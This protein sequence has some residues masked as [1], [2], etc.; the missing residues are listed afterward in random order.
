MQGHQS[1][2]F[3]LA[4]SGANSG[5]HRL[6]IDGAHFVRTYFFGASGYVHGDDWTGFVERDNRKRDLHARACECQRE[7]RDCKSTVKEVGDSGAA[8]ARAL[9][10]KRLAKN[11]RSRF[12][13][14]E[15]CQ[16][17]LSCKGEIGDVAAGFRFAADPLTEIVGNDKMEAR[18]AVAAARERC[19][20]RVDALE[21]FDQVVDLHHEARLFQHFAGDPFGEYGAYAYDGPVG[22]SS[23][24]GHYLNRVEWRVR[25]EEV[26][27]RQT[28]DFTR[29]VIE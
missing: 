5:E 12:G 17:I 23:G 2:D 13:Q 3:L 10:G 6:Q 20:R 28:V 22:K 25:L 14:L 15:L 26:A 4:H 7:H 9:H 27:P 1:K 24:R 8:T 29:R 11:T 19:I 16:F 18:T 21:D